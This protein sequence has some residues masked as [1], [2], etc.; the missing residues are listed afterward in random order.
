MTFGPEVKFVKAPSAE[1]GQNLPPSAGL[2]FF[3]LV[4]IDGGTE[5][6][7][8]RLMDRDDNELYKTTLDPVRAA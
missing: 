4:D 6:L 5:Q 7:T 1:Q 2:Q 8:V 3:G